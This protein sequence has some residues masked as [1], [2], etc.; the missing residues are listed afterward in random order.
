[1]IRPLLVIICL[2]ASAATA[3][4][5]CAWVLWAYSVSSVREAWSPDSA[6]QSQ[7]ACQAKI[8]EYIENWRTHKEKGHLEETEVLKVQ[9]TSVTYR[10]KKNGHEVFLRYTCLPDTVDPRGPKGR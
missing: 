7:N 9:T 1:M 10:L 8:A 4:A 5:E 3:A 6:A 2:F